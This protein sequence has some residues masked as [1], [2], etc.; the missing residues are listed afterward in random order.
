MI[1]KE[2]DRLDRTELAA[3]RKFFSNYKNADGLVEPHKVV[4]AMKEFGF[5]KSMPFVFEFL[6]EFDT[7]DYAN[8]IEYDDF[9]DILNARLN[10]MR[11]DRAI[12]RLFLLFK[13]DP[14][15]FVIEF[16]DLKR[17]ATEV[18]DEMTDE[19][20]NNMLRR[21]S[22]GAKDLDYDHFYAAMRKEIAQPTE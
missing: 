17:V 12:E 16:K 11:S 5:E 20:I 4:E 8:G 2:K 3:V 22:G 14:N 1:L 18:G 10:D 6:S 19:E 21:L 13:K 9:V 7:K 15:A